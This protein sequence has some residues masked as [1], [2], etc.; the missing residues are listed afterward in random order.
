[1]KF[2]EAKMFITVLVVMSC[3]SLKSVYSP[4]GTIFATGSRSDLVYF[5]FLPQA[6]LLLT[7]LAN[8]DILK[9]IV[10]HKLF[11][12]DFDLLMVLSGVPIL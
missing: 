8:T 5:W 4:S 7:Q 11:S 10:F 9:K 2:S 6:L 3:I 1:M 12:A